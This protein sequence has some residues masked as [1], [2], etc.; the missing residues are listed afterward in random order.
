MPTSAGGTERRFSVLPFGGGSETTLNIPGVADA[1]RWTDS[2]TVRVAS[3]TAGGTRV[4]LLDVRTGAV[5]RSVDIAD[6]LRRRA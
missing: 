2:V 4:S 1:R 6:S 5:G 3:Q